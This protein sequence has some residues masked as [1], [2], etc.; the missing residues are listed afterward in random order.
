MSLE[1]GSS[2]CTHRLPACPTALA[3]LLGCSADVFH[4]LSRA[5]QRACIARA[6]SQHGQGQVEGQGGG[7]REG[8]VEGQGQ[9]G[10]LG[11]AQRQGE[12]RGGRFA[13]V[14]L[15]DR[16][17]R[18]GVCDQEQGEG[19]GKLAVAGLVLPP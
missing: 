10:G 8:Q 4:T 13:V 11:R 17:G 1:D 5:Q 12:G 7:L 19:Q 2:T 14:C 16:G 9:G 3:S 15:V 6:T 18:G